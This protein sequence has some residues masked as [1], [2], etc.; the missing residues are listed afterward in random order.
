MI[1]EPIHLSQYCDDWPRWFE[2]D[3]QELIGALGNQLRGVEHF[4]STSVPHLLAKPII[5]ILMAPASWPPSNHILDSLAQLGYEYLGDAGVPGREYLR[6][7]TQPHTN[8]A[9]VEWNGSL[10]RLNLAIHDLLRS[11]ASAASAYA[12]AKQHAWAHGARTLLAYSDAKAPFLRQLLKAAEE[13]CQRT[14]GLSDA[15]ALRAGSRCPALDGE[16]HRYRGT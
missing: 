8:L 11:D 10:W 1:D 2:Q 12:A 3:T 6:R 4:G 13:P 14:N 16:R 15:D 9:M 7:R 5:D